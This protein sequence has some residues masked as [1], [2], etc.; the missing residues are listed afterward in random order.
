MIDRD[1]PTDPPDVLLVDSSS[2]RI[3]RTKRAFRAERDDI[4]LH[5]VHDDAACLDFLR[6]R[7]EYEDAP[8]PGLV[9]LRTEPS[10]LLNGDSVLETIADDAALARIPLV[11]C[12]PTTAPTTAVR[13]AYDRRANAVV[14]HPA[15]EEKE[16]FV[17]TMRLLV[18]FWIAAVRLPPQPGPTE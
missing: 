14:E 1:D 16:E 4:S 10:T 17:R 6:Q 11:V 3:E 12:L 15:D 5:V 7:G 9:V 8:E 18:R 13:R 2:D